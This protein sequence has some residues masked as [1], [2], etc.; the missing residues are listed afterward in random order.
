VE[1]VREGPGEDTSRTGPK[2]GQKEATAQVSGPRIQ[3]HDHAKYVA[4]IRNRAIDLVNKDSSSFLARLCRD[5][6][7]DQW[8]LNI[9]QKDDKNYFFTAYSWDP[10]SGEWARSFDS[11]KQP[12]ARWKHHIRASESGRECRVL[13]GNLR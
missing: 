13:K 4:R 8:S 12:L 6:I 11:G 5:T 3:K 7:T 2:A 1:S 9:Y 10:V